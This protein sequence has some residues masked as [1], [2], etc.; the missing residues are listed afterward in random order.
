MTWLTNSFDRTVLGIITGL[1]I[2]IGLVILLGD[3][4]GVPI[5]DLQPADESTPSTTSPIRVEF[6]QDMNTDGVESRFYIAP[7]VEGEFQ[8]DGNTLMFQ[9]TFPLTAGQTYTVIVD[10]G[11]QSTNGRATKQPIRWSFT[12]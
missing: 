7:V 11:A 8:W 5:R 6:G 9:P 12:P 10:A 4:V 1:T 3:H 2:I